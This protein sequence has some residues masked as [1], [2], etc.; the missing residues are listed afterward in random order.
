MWIRV[1]AIN[2]SFLSA[3]TAPPVGVADK[4]RLLL[5][6]ELQPR[7]ILVWLLGRAK[8]PREQA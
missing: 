3:L 8:L 1:D 2:S 4:E 6:E 7:E 5:G